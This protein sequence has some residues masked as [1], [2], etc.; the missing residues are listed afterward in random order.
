[1]PTSISQN[2]IEEVRM[3]TDILELV[4]GYVTLK[5][6]G[7]N[8]FGLCPFHNEKTASFSVNTEKQIFHCFGCGAGGNAFTFLMQHEGVSFP[9]SVKSLAQRAN[10]DV[11]WE[12]RD[13]GQSKQNE[14]LYYVNEFASGWYQQ[15]LNEPAGQSALSYLTGRAL[16]ADVIK[17]FG[18]GFAPAGWDG[19]IKQAEKTANDIKVLIDAGLVLDKEDG[20]RYDRFRDRIMFPIRNLSGRVVGFGGRIMT[21]QPKSPKYLNSPETPIYEKSKV[22]YGLFQ[23]KDAIRRQD[24]AIFVEGYMDLLGLQSRDVNNTV[25]TSGTALT[26]E[27]A[28]LIRRYT[29]NIVLMYDSDAAGSSAALRGADVLLENG[30]EVSVAKLPAGHDPDSFVREAGKDALLTIVAEAKQLFDYKLGLVLQQPAEKRGDGIGSLLESVMRLEDRVQRSLIIAKIAEGLGM[31]ERDL[32]PKFKKMMQTSKGR[33]SGAVIDHQ[34]PP[35][36]E[37]A[38]EDLTRILLHDWSVAEL[39]FSNLELSHLREHRLFAVLEF[40]KNQYKGEQ[41]PAREHLIQRFRNVD[42][43]AF[44]SKEMPEKW[45]EMDLS[46]VA[47]DCLR[48]IQLEKLQG[49]IESVRAKLKANRD[50]VEARKTLLARC[51]A[52]ENEKMALSQKKTG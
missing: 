32:W 18:L 27:Q 11:A 31:N 6:K 12:E 15:L 22:L 35:K 10:I 1:M 42:I 28:A 13:D 52:L 8:Y 21:E 44:L 7:Q 50:G 3:A 37:W 14:A 36:I 34:L 20:K 23:N 16:N 38:V 48:T 46:R 29:R 30:L 2:Q 39:V 5:K 17:T 33:N 19:L 43:S 49:E 25:A 40:M 24:Q 47:R 26:A 45:Q 4:S 51:M 9:E 41:T